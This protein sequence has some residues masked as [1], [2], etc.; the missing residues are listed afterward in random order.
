MPLYLSNMLRTILY[1]CK[2]LFVFIDSIKKFIFSVFL[3][4]QVILHSDLIW[5]SIQVEMVPALVSLD[6]M[7]MVLMYVKSVIIVAKLALARQIIN[8]LYVQR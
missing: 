3:A 1:R 8:V 2:K 5:Q 4:K 6:I 7:T